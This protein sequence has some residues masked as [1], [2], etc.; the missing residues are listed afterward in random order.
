MTKKLCK[1]C[2]YYRRDWFSHLMGMG[3]RHDTC[4]SPNTST[5]LVTGKEHRFCDM[6]RAHRWDEL[7]WS[8]GAEGKF[9][10]AR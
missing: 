5:N 4:T 6:L 2:K 3:D 8:C 10:E 9:W 7:D 1:D